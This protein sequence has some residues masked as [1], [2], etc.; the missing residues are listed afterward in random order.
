MKYLVYEIQTYADGTIGIPPVP[1]FDKY[2]D[3]QARYYSILAAAA[4]SNLPIHTAEIVDNKGKV[5]IK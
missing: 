4:I 3:A 1:S 5:Y 2:S